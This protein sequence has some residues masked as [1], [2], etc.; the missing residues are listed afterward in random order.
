MLTTIPSI[1]DPVFSPIDRIL[2][3]VLTVIGTT[4]GP[5]ADTITALFSKF[6]LLLD[7]VRCIVDSVMTTLDPGINTSCYSYM[8]ECESQGHSSN[9]KCVFIHHRYTLVRIS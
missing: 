1:V 8:A 3:L 5:I 6:L 7:A 4:V 9:E 2:S